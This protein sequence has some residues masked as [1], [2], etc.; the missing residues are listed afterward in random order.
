MQLLHSERDDP[1]PV[2]IVRDA[3]SAAERHEGVPN[4]EDEEGNIST[5]V[6]YSFYQWDAP[7]GTDVFERPLHSAP[8]ILFCTS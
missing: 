1:E 8:V 5:I 7:R 2:H 3:Q 6:V 4:Q